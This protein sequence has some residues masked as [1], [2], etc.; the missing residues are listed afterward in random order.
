MWGSAIVGFGSYHYKYTSGNEGDSALTGFAVRGRE[1]DVHIARAF[2][3][4]DVL[5][6]KL[7]KYRDF[8]LLYNQM[9]SAIQVKRAR[10][11]RS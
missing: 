5:L 1:V 8:Q 7:G 11:E 10:G 2:E 4:R 9:P 3:G 6:A